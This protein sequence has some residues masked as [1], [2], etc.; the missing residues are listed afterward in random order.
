M[1]NTRREV[2]EAKAGYGDP[3]I[4]GIYFS[5]GWTDETTHR[6]KIANQLLGLVWPWIDDS[7]LEPV[8]RLWQFEY[9]YPCGTVSVGNCARNASRSGYNLAS[10]RGRCERLGSS[11]TARHARITR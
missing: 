6:K 9:E 11:G 1:K 5:T 3:P 7:L 4:G 8:R 2:R 10:D